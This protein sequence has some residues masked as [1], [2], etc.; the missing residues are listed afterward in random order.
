MLIQLQAEEWRQDGRLHGLEYSFNLSTGMFELTWCPENSWVQAAARQL[1]ELSRLHVRGLHEL[2]APKACHSSGGIKP[3]KIIFP[4]RLFTVWFTC[5]VQAH[6]CAWR[7]SSG[8]SH[9]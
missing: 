3:V 1:T 7:P 6:A 2:L 9:C 5:M 4:V 8:T